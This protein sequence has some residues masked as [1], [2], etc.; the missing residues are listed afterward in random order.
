MLYPALGL[1]G[2]GLSFIY[3]SAMPAAIQSK[4]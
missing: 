1:F 4:Q 2:F 3:Q